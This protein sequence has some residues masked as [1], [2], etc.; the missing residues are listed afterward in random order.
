MTKTGTV[1]IQ[2]H[3]ITF[4]CKFKVVKKTVWWRRDKVSSYSFQ[5]YE[6]TELMSQG[7]S[8]KNVKIKPA[9]YLDF[10]GLRERPCISENK[11]I[12]LWKER[13]RV[14]CPRTTHIA[15]NYPP[16]IKSHA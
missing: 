12:S 4:P 8:I 11:F 5:W 1:N 9:Y 6:I 16:P 13:I 2:G 14:G 3:E 7:L 10:F 15:P